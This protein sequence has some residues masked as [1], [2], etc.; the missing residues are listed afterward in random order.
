MLL[1]EFVKSERNGGVKGRNVDTAGVNIKLTLLCTIVSP[2]NKSTF[3]G[4]EYVHVL[5]QNVV[6]FLS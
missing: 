2:S 1:K 3:G 4:V 6:T 5:G